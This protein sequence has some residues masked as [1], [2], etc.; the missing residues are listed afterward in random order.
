[1]APERFTE[2]DLLKGLDKWSSHADELAEPLPHELVSLNRSPF[3]YLVCL[4]I[5]RVRRLTQ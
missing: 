2:E 5:W 4:I 3:V 1:M